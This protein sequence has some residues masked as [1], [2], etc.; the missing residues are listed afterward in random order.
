MLRPRLIVCLL[1]ENSRLVK[2]IKFSNQRYIG[3]PLNAVKIYNELKCDELVFFDIGATKNNS[4]INYKLLDQIAKESRMPLCYGGY[5]SSFEEAKKVINLGFE[6]ISINNS[7]LKNPEFVSELGKKLGSQSIVVTL[8]VFKKK[9]LL[10]TEYSCKSLSKM[11]T[12]NMDPISLGL[13][14]QELGAGELIFN[15]ID[16]DGTQTGYDLDYIQ[17]LKN[18]FNIPITFLGGAKDLKDVKELLNLYGH[19][20]CA[21]GSMFIY[22]G[23]LNGVLIN[24]PSSSD[25]INLLEDKYA[26]K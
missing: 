21:A 26:K 13:K 1:I 9:S 11:K 16:K 25:K 3:D 12:I 19:C 10:K 5:I 18:K 22:K 6:K 15:F 2:T 14:A 7:F 17:K 20:G 8:D 23:K 24:Y 4:N